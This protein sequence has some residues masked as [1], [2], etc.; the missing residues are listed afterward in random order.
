MSRGLRLNPIERDIWLE[1]DESL[2]ESAKATM[3]QDGA[4]EAL[5]QGETINRTALGYVPTHDTFVDGMKGASL[6]SAKSTSTVVFEFHLLVEVIQ[7][8]DAMLLLNSPIGERP[9]RDALR[10][11]RN[12]VWFADDVVF[13]DPAH[14]P[15]AEQYA[16]LNAVP[17]A[18]K[19]E[20]GLS[21]QAPEGVYEGTATLAKRKFGQVAYIGFSYRSFPGGWVGEWAQSKG[22][23]AIAK[24]RGGRSSGHEDWLTRQPAIII[25][26]GR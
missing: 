25:D 3:L 10:Y 16:V 2:S 19:I 12:H 23:Q 18:R 8:V 11:S 17:Y 21:P 26:P 9:K 15:P 13:D 22:A 4:R 1:L 6:T 14:P 7:Y 24:G 5:L 20:R